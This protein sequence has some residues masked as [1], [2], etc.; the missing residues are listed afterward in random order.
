MDT[1]S[2]KTRWHDLEESV[3][4]FPIPIVDAES[5]SMT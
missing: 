1:G 5:S 2:N 4:I 3:G